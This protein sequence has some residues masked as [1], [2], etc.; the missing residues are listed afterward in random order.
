MGSSLDFSS[1]LETLY[2]REA[3]RSMIELLPSRVWSGAVKSRLARALDKVTGLLEY[4]MGFLLFP[5][6]IMQWCAQVS[7]HDFVLGRATIDPFR[8]DVVDC[9]IILASN[10]L[11][12]A[13]EKNERGPGKE[14]SA[15][16]RR[17]LSQIR[18]CNKVNKADIYTMHKI[19][20]EH[21]SQIGGHVASIL[22]VSEDHVSEILNQRIG[23]KDF[24][25]SERIREMADGNFDFRKMNYIWSTAETIRVHT[26]GRSSQRPYVEFFKR[27][28]DDGLADAFYSHNRL[29]DKNG[30]RVINKERIDPYEALRFPAI[31]PVASELLAIASREH[32]TIVCVST[33]MLSK[34]EYR[35]DLELGSEDPGYIQSV[36]NTYEDNDDGYDVMDDFDP[37][38]DDE[39]GFKP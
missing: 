23:V 22:G 12:F 10:D 17:L 35:A 24:H 3:V 2:G 20:K 16:V 33:H 39:P 19:A 9:L 5:E 37:N 28:R 36:V 14:W 26:T 21:L 30:A 29:V 6:R 7:E 18:T 27:I 11:D 34:L 1:K 25:L 8:M 32:D 15:E 31:P 13:H 4:D 38:E